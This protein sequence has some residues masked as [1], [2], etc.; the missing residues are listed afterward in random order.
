MRIMRIVNVTPH[1]HS[2]EFK[3]NIEPSVAVNPLNPDEMVITAFTFKEDA[4]P[5]S[6]YYFSV[7]GGET[8]GAVFGIP[9]ELAQDPSPSFAQA[10]SQLY[11]G[12]LLLRSADYYVLRSSDRKLDAKIIKAN[13]DA[14][15]PWAEAT[16]VIGGPDNGKDRLYV[17]Y[18]DDGAATVDVF[19]DAAQPVPTFTPIVLDPRN[20]P[21]GNGPEIRTVVHGDG[22]VYVA[23]KSLHFFD[24][25]ENSIAD[26]VVARDDNWGAGLGGAPFTNLKDP[27]DGLSG[28]RV[29]IAVPIHGGNLGG[30]RLNNDCNIAVDP[31]NSSVVYLTWCDNT[32]SDYTLR[33]RK[34]TNRGV[35]WSDDLLTVPNATLATMTINSGGTVGLM[36]QQ[37]VSKKMETHFRTTNNGGRWD[38]TLMART[39]PSPK[40][41]GDYGRL[42]TVGLDFYGSFPAMNSP[43]PR[44][45]FPNGGGTVRFQRNTRGKFLIGLDGRTRIPESVDL[46]FVK[47]LEQ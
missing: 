20:P 34:S 25:K 32:T 47:V 38:D 46:F 41:A 19:P 4:N 35:D 8:W 14:D 37:L 18:N 5:K 42:V 22:T 16:T 45:F 29:A 2:D 11:L 24:P 6:V 40:F 43:D 10:S 17:G 44:N 12:T 3:R 28:R 1:D 33:V 23:Y 39:K 36:Y 7:D 31:T 21:E 13:G 15:Q 27:V 30:V 26:L 9:G